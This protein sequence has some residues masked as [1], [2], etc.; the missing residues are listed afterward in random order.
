[1]AEN[2]PD[3]TFSDSG[4]ELPSDIGQQIRWHTIVESLEL[5]HLPEDEA[6]DIRQA[7]RAVHERLDGAM[8]GR[9]MVQREGMFLFPLR[10]TPGT[11][12][13]VVPEDDGRVFY[14]SRQDFLA[15][16]KGDPAEGGYEQLFH[17]DAKRWELVT[18]FDELTDILRDAGRLV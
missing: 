14:L 15:V 9:Q 5:I 17:V 1:M 3:D 4:G 2:S 11:Y 10:N 6:A 12:G 13:W 8:A 16:F 7:Y 18:D